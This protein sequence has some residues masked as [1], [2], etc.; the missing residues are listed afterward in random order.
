MSHAIAQKERY[1]RAQHL[2]KGLKVIDE[3]GGMRAAIEIG[4]P[5]QGRC[6]IGGAPSETCTCWYAFV[7]GYLCARCIVGE[8]SG[9]CPCCLGN[10]VAVGGV[11]DRWNADNLQLGLRFEYNGIVHVECNKDRLNVVEAVGPLSQD[12]QADVDFDARS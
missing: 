3:F 1:I 12:V 7:H 4:K 11:C 5:E 6:C 2:S 8:G 9:I 10:D